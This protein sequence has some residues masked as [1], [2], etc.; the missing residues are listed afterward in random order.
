MI[1]LLIGTAHAQQTA[2]APAAG[3][4]AAYGQFAP[5][6]LIFVVFYVLIIR[7]Q[8]KKAQEQQSFL[9]NLKKGD[10]VLTSG[11]VH[12][13][14]TGLTDTAVTLEIA[15]N[16]RVKVHR[17]YVLPMPPAEDKAAPAKKG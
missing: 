1:S 7:P 3:G 14:I 16:V 4:L 10:K 2:A 11:G 15:E 5:F 8:Q 13:T 12:G 6:I 9:S 17:G